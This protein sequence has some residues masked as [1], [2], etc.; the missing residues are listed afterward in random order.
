MTENTAIL[1]LG[2]GFD[3]H[4]GYKTRY[5]DFINSL[6]EEQINAN[7]WYTYFN[8][9]SKYQSWIDIEAQMKNIIDLMIS[10]EIEYPE[11][12]YNESI[13]VKYKPV[14]ELFNINW[15]YSKK[16]LGYEKSIGKTFKEAA[17]IAD[18]KYITSYSSFDTLVYFNF[19]KKRKKLIEDFSRLRQEFQQYLVSVTKEQPII[20]ENIKNKLSV[21]DEILVLNFNYTDTLSSYGLEY[22]QVYIHE[23]IES[24]IVLGHNDIDDPRYAIFKKSV[25]QK[26]LP[27]SYLNKF[28]EILK[29][30]INNAEL[31]I[32]GHSFDVNDHNV[33]NGL[34]KFV[35]LEKIQLNKVLMYYYENTAED[36]EL[37][38]KF[39]NMSDLIQREYNVQL[40][41]QKSIFTYFN[42]NYDE[43]AGNELLN[44]MDYDGNIERIKL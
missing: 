1:I 41:F 16:Y 12:N 9:K 23:N 14:Y 35:S 33:I 44:A 40:Y 28:N 31:I 43:V 27:V 21:Y 10:L 34:L 15:S 11:L 36:G 26:L 29:R 22:K 4:N 5:S 38:D 25:Q 6:T 20:D 24:E 37:N 19:E 42:K 17:S 13:S 2:N 32:I 3:I 8:K 39:L 18:Y 30:T 7:C